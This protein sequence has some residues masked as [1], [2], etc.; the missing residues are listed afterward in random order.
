M[1]RFFD[2]ADMVGTRASAA[3]TPARD[4]DIVRITSA[5]AGARIAIYDG[6]AA[7][8]RVEDVVADDLAEAIEQLA[9]R[10]YNIARERGGSVPYTIIREVAENLIHAGFNEVVV[11]I[12][13]RRERR[14]VRRPGPGHP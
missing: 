4:A 6:L 13:D 9:S 7:A 1:K 8:P 11:T 5:P 2:T 3:A 12:L 10:T 14:A